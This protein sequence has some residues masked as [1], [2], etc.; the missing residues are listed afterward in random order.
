MAVDNLQV[1]MLS[2]GSDLY[3]HLQIVRS[4]SLILAF[5]DVVLKHMKKAKGSHSTD[6]E[7]FFSHR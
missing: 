5:S 1:R 2:P 4:F 3:A 7:G 6:T